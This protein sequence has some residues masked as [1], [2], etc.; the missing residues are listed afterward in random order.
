MADSIYLLYGYCL[1]MEGYNPNVRGLS[2]ELEMDSSLDDV[3]NTA[4]NR[5]VDLVILDCAL[6]RLTDKAFERH[7]A[8]ASSDSRWDQDHLEIAFKYDR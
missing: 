3:L 2:K 6:V 7:D 4:G 5:T 1:K 8:D